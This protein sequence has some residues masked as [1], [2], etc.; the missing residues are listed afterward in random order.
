MIAT[1]YSDSIAQVS[2][3]MLVLYPLCLHYLHSRKPLWS[4][5]SSTKR[6]VINKISH[7]FQSGVTSQLYMFEKLR[8]SLFF[9]TSQ[10]LNWT[11]RGPSELWLIP[12]DFLFRLSLEQQKGLKCPEVELEKN[13]QAKSEGGIVSVD[14]QCQTAY[15]LSEPSINCR[16]V[17]EAMCF[18]VKYTVI[19]FSFHGHYTVGHKGLVAWLDGEQRRQTHEKLLVDER[20]S[21]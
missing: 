3:V 18:N 12:S 15:R 20:P 6:F 1:N 2:L 9:I 14:R 10:V 13:K 8:M 11:L 21:W 16:K 4:L 5:C 17:G 19:L 7:K